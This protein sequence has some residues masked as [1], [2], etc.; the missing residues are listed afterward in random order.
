MYDER[1][2]E[3]QVSEFNGRAIREYHAF[4]DASERWC[5]AKPEGGESWKDVRNRVGDFL[6]D[7]EKKH[8][9]KTILIVS[10]NSPLRMMGA[11]CNG[12]TLSGTTFDHDEDGKRYENGEVRE[13]DFVPL[14]HNDDY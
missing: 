10:H 7:I 3:I 6:Y 13:L 12:L 9:G 14:P 2:G 8:Q 5:E 1:L 11:V 4:L